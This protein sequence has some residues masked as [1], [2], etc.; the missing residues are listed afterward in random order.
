MRPIEGD[1]DVLIGSLVGDTNADGV[2]DLSDTLLARHELR[3]GA[4]PAILARNDV[5]VNGVLNLCD[6]LLIKSLVTVPPA[7]IPITPP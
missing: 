6:V 7:R 5:N 3:T 1:R 2:L 4:F